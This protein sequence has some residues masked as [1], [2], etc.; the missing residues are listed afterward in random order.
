M[1]AKVIILF[2]VRKS[3][4]QER[5][6]R[7]SQ[8]AVVEKILFAKGLGRPAHHAGRGDRD[9][10]DSA[11]LV[12][13]ISADLLEAAAAKKLAAARDVV[14]PFKTVGC[15]TIALFSES[16]SRNAEAGV[17]LELAQQ[18]LQVVWIEGK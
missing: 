12:G 1:S 3:R 13:D 7:C 5:A 18:E 17:F 11:R 16:C 10:I 15:R 2:A 8:T 14:L 4:R 9:P 6:L